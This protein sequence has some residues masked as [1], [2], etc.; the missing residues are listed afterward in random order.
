MV[1]DSK[2][3]DEF[4]VEIFETREQAELF[5]DTYGY[6][7]DGIETHNL[8]EKGDKFKTS[9]IWWHVSPIALFR[10][11]NYDNQ[12]CLDDIRLINNPPNDI[13]ENLNIFPSLFDSQLVE[14]NVKAN[15]RQ[16]AIIKANK[17]CKELQ[18]YFKSVM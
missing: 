2:D 8:Y 16:E 18:D 6:Y 5:C 15:N 17:R 9:D 7:K 12:I 14:F 3:Y 4:M 1:M 11:A 10:V 13:D